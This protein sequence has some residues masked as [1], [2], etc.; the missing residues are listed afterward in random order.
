MRCA[1]AQATEHTEE[2]KRGTLMPIAQILQEGGR[3]DDAAD[4]LREWCGVSDA[5]AALDAF[6]ELLEA[7]PAGL[8]SL[9]FTMDTK[10]HWH[11]EQTYGRDTL[12]RAA[13]DRIMALATEDHR[14]FAVLRVDFSRHAIQGA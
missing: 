14:R 4:V 12:D 10:G 13:F 3:Y 2:E 7:S 5:P 6:C 11:H 9:E 1:R 8:V